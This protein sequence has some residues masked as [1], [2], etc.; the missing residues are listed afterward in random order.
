MD[1]DEIEEENHEDEESEVEELIEGNHPPNFILDHDEAEL[2]DMEDCIEI[3]SYLLNKEDHSS[4]TFTTITSTP[5][6]TFTEELLKK[7]EENEKDSTIN[8]MVNVAS[9]PNKLV[10]SPN[11]IIDNSCFQ[12][13]FGRCCTHNKS[14][15]SLTI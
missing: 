12:A 11:S 10:M 1:V 7:D 9:N 15:F 14:P 4:S 6:E 3:D 8:P 5:I 13:F 2:D